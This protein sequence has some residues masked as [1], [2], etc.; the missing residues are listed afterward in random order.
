MHLEALGG[1]PKSRYKVCLLFSEGGW[2][3]KYFPQVLHRQPIFAVIY[4]Y[5]YIYTFVH[6]YG[7]WWQKSRVPTF[8]IFIIVKNRP[9]QLPNPNL[10]EGSRYEFHHALERQHV[11]PLRQLHCFNSSHALLFCWPK[12]PR[13]QESGLLH[14]WQLKNGRILFKQWENPGVKKGDAFWTNG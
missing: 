9:G 3:P 11:T 14:S 6:T 10:T 1:I 8:S 5:I 13:T 12:V 2:L 7:T 4:T